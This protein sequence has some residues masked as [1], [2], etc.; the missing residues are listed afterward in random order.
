M[1]NKHKVLELVLIGVLCITS[2]VIAEDKKDGNL[3]SHITNIRLE[4]IRP[5]TPEGESWGQSSWSPDSKKIYLAHPTNIRVFDIE[6]ETLID[7]PILSKD[8]EGYIG[9]RVWSTDGNKI[10]LGTDILTEPVKGKGKIF[11]AENM[12]VD[13]KAKKVKKISLPTKGQVE[14]DNKEFCCY[15]ISKTQ[16]F[17]NIQYFDENGKKMEHPPKLSVTKLIIDDNSNIWE[18]SISTD[19]KQS[20]NLITINDDVK[21]ETGG[22]YRRLVYSKNRMYILVNDEYVLDNK[23]NLLCDLNGHGS[24]SSDGQFILYQITEEDGEVTLSSDLFMWDSITKNTFQLTTTPTLLE[25]FEVLSPD[26]KK[27]IFSEEKNLAI[28]EADVIYE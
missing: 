11:V 4:N 20:K 2:Y 14:W 22:N 8:T 13:L 6:T 28:Y 15:E 27:L 17:I 16:G 23:G 3:P 19:G 5:I 24:W 7:I 9:I 26:G 12:I 21:N 1:K 18:I 10:V 25:S